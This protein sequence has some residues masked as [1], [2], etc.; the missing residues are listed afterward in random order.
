MSTPD[1]EA[2]FEGVILWLILWLL[3]RKRKLAKGIVFGVYIIGY[4]FFRFVI[5]YFREPDIGIGYPIQ[6]VKTENPTYLFVTP[7]NFTTGQIFNFLMIAGG[8]I[9][10]LFARS[11][12]KKQAAK[13]QAVQNKPSARK[14][15]KKIR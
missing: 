10:I 8:V 15:R 7:W 2:L 4:G 1:A 14:I 6:F 11:L 13:K 3:F 5:E 9:L 12:S